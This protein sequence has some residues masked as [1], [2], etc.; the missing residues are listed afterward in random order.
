MG[1]VL[2]YFDGYVVTL[3]NITY[4]N[5]YFKVT[6]VYFAYFHSVM[7]QSTVGHLVIERT[8]VQLLK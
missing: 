3:S 5:G 4:E 2:F 1:N 6:I 8:K 7:S